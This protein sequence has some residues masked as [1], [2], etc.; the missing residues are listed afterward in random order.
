MYTTHLPTLMPPRHRL[1]CTFCTFLTAGNY[2]VQLYDPNTNGFA[3]SSPGIG[4]HVEIRDPTDKIILSKA[5]NLV[6]Y[7]VW[8]LAHCATLPHVEV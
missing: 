2:K 5:S 7:C 4:M 8:H 1:T 3:P 6:F